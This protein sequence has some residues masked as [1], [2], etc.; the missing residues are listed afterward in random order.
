MSAWLASHPRRATE[1]AV[2]RINRYAHAFGADRLYA[3]VNTPLDDL[4]VRCP[5]TRSYLWLKRCLDWYVAV[6]ALLAAAPLL[7]L[8]ALLIRRDSPGPALFR[9]TRAGLH[10]RPFTLLKFRTMRTGVDPYGDSP[11]SGRDP[12]LTR[13]GRWL[14][15]T[16][17]DELPQFWN[18]LRGDL[19]LVGP[20]PL[21]VQQIAEW[22]SRQRGRLLVKPGLTGL[23]QV[24]G[25][26]N[27]TI[28]DKLEWDVR[29]VEQAGL[30]TDL[31]IL[32][33]TL[34]GLARR[35]G[36]YEVR[37]SRTRSR[38]SPPITSEPGS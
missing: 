8:I 11:Q 36:I 37:Y 13:V 20:R 33:Q 22:N 6:V 14:R 31:R 29:Y 21:Y 23:A 18:V 10:G 4:P 5:A 3:A 35:T 34:A 27:L 9:Q 17:L 1:A 12:R 30:R 25:R 38:R 28:E 26:A 24:H 32:A 15:E 2:V 16:S 19:S 7:A